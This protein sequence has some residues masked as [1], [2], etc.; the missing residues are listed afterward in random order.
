MTY[1]HTLHCPLC[2]LECPAPSDM[3]QRY[4]HCEPCAQRFELVA[5]GGVAGQRPTIEVGHVSRPAQPERLHAPVLIPLGK[6]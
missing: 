4:T 3:L 6:V 1:P 5:P 2:G